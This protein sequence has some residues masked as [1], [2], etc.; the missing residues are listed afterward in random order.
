MCIISALSPPPNHERT[1]IQ[2]SSNEAHVFCVSSNKTTN[3]IV[4]IAHLSMSCL[5]VCRW[6]HRGVMGRGWRK[7]ASELRPVSTRPR[8]GPGQHDWCFRDVCSDRLVGLG[9][10][11]SEECISKPATQVARRLCPTR[12]DTELDC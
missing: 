11:D 5:S 7:T 4:L 12:R 8:R 6:G 2:T 9:W 1:N 3:H 10:V